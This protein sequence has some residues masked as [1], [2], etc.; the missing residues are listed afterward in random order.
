M[1]GHPWTVSKIV[2]CLIKRIN[3]TISHSDDV[4]KTIEENENTPAKLINIIKMQGPINNRR[5][6]LNENFTLV[7]AVI[8]DLIRDSAEI[9]EYLTHVKDGI[10][11]PK[12]ASIQSI[13]IFKTGP[14]FG[15]ELC[16]SRIIP[17]R[18][19]QKLLSLNTKDE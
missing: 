14:V 3:S 2:K 10:L 12:L 4:E 9:L 5:S 17:Y 6:D 7:N 1:D 15:I 18:K 19:F 8:N 16:S 13:F 11:R